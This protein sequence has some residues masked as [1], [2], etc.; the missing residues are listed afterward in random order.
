MLL[1]DVE[2]KTTIACIPPK[3]SVKATEKPELTI[4]MFEMNAYDVAFAE[5]L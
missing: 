5:Y 3:V 1:T 4:M 2:F